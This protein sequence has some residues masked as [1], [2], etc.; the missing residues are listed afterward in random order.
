MHKQQH[1]ATFRTQQSGVPQPSPLRVNPA[2]QVEASHRVEASEFPSPRAP[3]LA[4]S[5]LHHCPGCSCTL[6]STT[7]VKFGLK[8]CDWGADHNAVHAAICT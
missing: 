1:T 3:L 4:G 7:K 2:L 6:P 8:Q 5:C